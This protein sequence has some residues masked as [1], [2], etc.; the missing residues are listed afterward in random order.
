MPDIGS[1]LNFKIHTYGQLFIRI[2]KHCDQ[3]YYMAYLFNFSHIISKLNIFINV[4]MQNIN[5]INAY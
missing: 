4:P 1:W 2:K 5:S 3:R